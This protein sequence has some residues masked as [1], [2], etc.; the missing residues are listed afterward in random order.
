MI[1]VKSFNNGVKKESHVCNIYYYKKWEY[2]VKNLTSK[3]NNKI[4]IKKNSTL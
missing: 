2:L 3:K 1:I 4:N